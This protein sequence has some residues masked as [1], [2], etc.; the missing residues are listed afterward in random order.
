MEFS[1]PD[2]CDPQEIETQ[3]SSGYFLDDVKGELLDP[4]LTREA[5][6]DEVKVFGERRVYDVVPRASMPP[7]R[8]TI[9]VRWVDTN[10]G[11]STEPRIRSRLVCQEFAFGG[12]PGGDLFAPTPPLGATRLLLSALASRG[13]Y[14]PG[15]HRA[16]LLDFKR[17]FLYGDVERELFIELPDEDS[18]KLGG[19]SVGRLRKAMYGTLDAPAVWQRLVQRVLCS[20]GFTASRTIPCVYHHRGRQLRVGAHVDDFLVI[21]PKADLLKLRSDLKRDYEVDGIS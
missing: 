18:R 11:S 12:D 8:R 15:D 7:G 6:L 20:M 13:R 2:L 14:G 5:R 17:A 9:G 19:Q 3:E 21:S 10:K 4:K 16:M 1:R